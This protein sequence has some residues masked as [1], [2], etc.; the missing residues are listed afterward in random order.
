MTSVGLPARTRWFV[1]GRI[2]TALAAV[3]MALAAVFSGMSAG[4][5][6]K[7]MVVLP[8]AIAVVGVLAVLACTRFS[9]FVLLVL[10][11]RS[12]IDLFKLSGSSAGN[13]ATNT[14]SRGLDPSSMLGALFLLAAAL[15]LC[16]QYF[17]T[18]HLRGSRLRLA[19]VSFG[20][21]G[22]IGV[23]G[24]AAQLVSLLEWLRIASVVMMY[25]VLE[26]L[27]SSDLMLR[28]VL[29][30]AYVSL[31][32]PLVYT[33]YTMAAG[34]PASEVKG[35]F[36]RITGPFSQANTF[37]RY[38]A[39]MIVFG[40][41]I[42][43][44]LSRRAKLVMAGLLSLSSVFLVLTLTRGALIATVFGIIVIAI[45]E[46][47]KALLAGLCAA[48]LAAAIALPGV[49]SR[50]AE[51]GSSRNIG[52]TPT[53]NTL[54]WR[55][56]Y[57]TEVLPLANSNPITGIGLNMT[58]YNTDAAKQPHNDF[59]RAYVE[60]GVLGLLTY[61]AWLAALVGNARRA[62]RAARPQTFE[63]AV[64][65]GALGCAWCFIVGSAAANVMS[66]VVCL[67]YLVTFAAAASF[68]ARGAPS[69]GV[70]AL[71]DSPVRED[72]HL[73]SVPRP[74]SD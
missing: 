40:V 7:R 13:T 22:L 46:R 28:R 41:A 2:F 31:L 27:I 70:T 34:N 10:G 49:S 66:N 20:A 56:D 38:L 48:V 11:V 8:I 61:V 42:L 68:I 59:I 26:Q 72:L 6:D 43:P 71:A 50:F 5:S 53:G 73:S 33:L 35:S 18:G 52:G 23:T 74:T 64:A 55:L 47:R 21:V 37:S 1:P 4:G 51:L 15:W 30:T 63:H 65:A 29:T 12:S 14:A 36:T 45:V 62:L 69:D 60:M 32:F 57:W 44:H 3:A 16:A 67:W 9:V 39:F 17:D 24:S 19:L 54:Q 25:V 58:Q